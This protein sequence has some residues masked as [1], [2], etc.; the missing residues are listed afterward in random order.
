[1]TSDDLLKLIG[2]VSPF[3]LLVGGWLV[4]RRLQ[5]SNAAKAA[6][7]AKLAEASA[8]KASIDVQAVI[9]ANTKSLLAEARG[10]QAEK[11]AIAQE[12]IAVL[13]QRT[14]RLESRFESLRT[15]LATHGIWDAA[16]LIDLRTSKPDYPSPPPF[17]RAGG[18]HY[19]DE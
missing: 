3:V 2:S 8:D 9:L 15:A 1:M 18:D 16:A 7:E 6:A 19:D 11:D 14:T 10:V 13:T 5:R 17:P 4:N 12:R